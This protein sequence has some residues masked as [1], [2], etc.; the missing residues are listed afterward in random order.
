[1]ELP[2]HLWSR[3]VFKKIGDFCGGFV[4]VDESIV[5]FKELQWARLLV[6]LEGIE[7]SS[8]L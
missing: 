5:A 6:K 7:W 4:A 1:M 8:S 2:L 3:E